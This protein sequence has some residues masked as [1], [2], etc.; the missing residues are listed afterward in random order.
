M[1]FA[2]EFHSL[3]DR[4]VSEAHKLFEDV[5]GGK[6]V[7]TA[8]QD[9]ANIVGDVKQQ[10]TDVANTVVSDLQ[11]DAGTVAS[12]TQNLT[13]TPQ[14]QVQTGGGAD[15]ST[16]P[17]ATPPAQPTITQPGGQVPQQPSA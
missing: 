10:A 3:L 6:A 16:L 7:E 17:Q 12:D 4:L 1:N 15:P 8:K 11:K 5:A 13:S 14:Q 2:Q 9:L